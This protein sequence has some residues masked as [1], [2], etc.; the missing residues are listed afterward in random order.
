MASLDFRPVSTTN[1]VANF[2]QAREEEKEEGCPK[3]RKCE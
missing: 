1:E 3:T 2:L